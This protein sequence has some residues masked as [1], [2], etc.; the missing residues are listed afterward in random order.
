MTPEGATLKIF[1]LGHYRKTALEENTSGLSNGRNTIKASD[2][3]HGHS[4]T[5]VPIANSMRKIGLECFDCQW[6]ASRKIPGK[7]ITWS[8][9][10]CPGSKAIGVT[11]SKRLSVIQN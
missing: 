4:N 10:D 1:E 11:A 3:S 9:T 5:A 7:R 6:Q 8:K 2:D